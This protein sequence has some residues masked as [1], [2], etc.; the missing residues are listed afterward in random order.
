MLGPP[1]L[2]PCAHQY[3]SWIGAQPATRKQ[4]PAASV[5]SR[6]VQSVSRSVGTTTRVADVKQVVPPKSSPQMKNTK[7]S[8][9]SSPRVSPVHESDAAYFTVK[10]HKWKTKKNSPVTSVHISTIKFK[11]SILNKE[12]LKR[13]Y[14]ASEFLP[15]IEISPSR[16]D[17]MKNKVK[18]VD[19]NI[20]FSDIHK[21]RPSADDFFGDIPQCSNQSDVSL[22][23]ASDLGTN[24]KSKGKVKKNIIRLPV[25]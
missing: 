7:S 15:D 19:K 18:K 22:T 23:S 10:T 3:V 17:L 6:L 14:Q 20:M 1:R 5:T 9:P 25:D 13:S 12:R 8:K 2:Q 16:S 4:R 11:G 24:V 21:Q